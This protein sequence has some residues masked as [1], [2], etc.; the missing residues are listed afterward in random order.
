MDAHTDGWMD[1]QTDGQ[2]RADFGTK[3]IYPIFLK[4]KSV[5]M[6]HPDFIVCGFMENSIGLKRVRDTYKIM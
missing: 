6:N 4:K 1:R 3:L 5:I 2:M